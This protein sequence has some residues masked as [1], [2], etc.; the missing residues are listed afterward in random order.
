MAAE[1]FSSLTSQRSTAAFMNL[2]APSSIAD[3]AA[4]GVFTAASAAY[5]LKGKAWDRPDPFHHVWFEKPQETDAAGNVRPKE[6]RNIAQK[7]EESGKQMVIFWGSQSG[8]A[9]AFAN[10]LVRECQAHFHISA[11]SADLSDYDAESIAALP[12]DKLA[13]FIVSTFGEGDPSDNAAELWSWIHGS[14]TPSLQ[15][16]RYFAFGLGNS[17]YKYYNKVVDVVVE[18]LD[19]YGARSLMPVG[20]ADDAKGATEEDFIG[21]KQSF[22]SVLKTDLGFEEFEASYQPTILVQ[23]DESL[24]PIDLHNG[25]P[26]HDANN[27]KALAACSPIKA[28]PIKETRELFTSSTRNCLHA[29]L[30]LTAFPE[31]TYKTGDHLSVWPSN[32]DQEVD[33][34]LRVL[35]LTDS[36]DI[37]ISIKALESST[38]VKV[39]TP[40]T[41][42][43]LL[44]YYL[45]ICAPVSRDVIIQLAQLA[46][47]ENAKSFLAQIGNDRSAYATYLEKTH[48]TFGRL[49]ELAVASDSVTW[50]S[51]PL[52]FVIEA[53]PT[54]Q[55]RHYSISSSSVVSPRNPTITAVVS[56]TALVG[57]TSQTIPGLAT[58]YMFAHHQTDGTNFALQGPNSALEGKKVYAHIRKSKFKLPTLSSQAIIMIAAGTGMAPFRGFI[59]ER[60]RLKQMGKPVG[61]M[62]L[63]FG[64]RSPEEDYLYAEE[65]A[66]LQQVLK[67]ELRIITAFSR[68][69]EKKVYV[70]DRVLEEKAAVLSLVG[71]ANANV[72]LC[73]SAAMAREV[74]NQIGGIM[75]AQ[76]GWT[77]EQV[78]EWSESKKKTKKFQEDVW[79]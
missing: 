52:A 30:D 13:V 56:S 51:L 4:L 7:L 50:S 74:G 48:V 21:W 36:K 72:Y 79:G 35:G 5:L 58:N 22:F 66:E 64:C 14:S 11:L 47:S 68:Q 28:L 17:N 20:R 69:G 63:F 6:T 19:K 65:L 49:L 55:P 70:Q 77:D 24:E 41:A 73:G 27:K 44:R 29:E 60:A 8:T 34:L 39:P 18:A 3:Y 25:E 53:L 62:L 38:K 40:T 15:N 37:P 76:N 45:E 67:D 57:D 43:V 12:Q 23:Q 2:G 59:Q 42:A 9:E 61:Q 31:I 32:P 78:K 46:P 54:L 26:V 75:K 1:I 33:R 16:L 71:E 10:R